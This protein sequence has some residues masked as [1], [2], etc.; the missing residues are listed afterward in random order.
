MN[1]WR[2]NELAGRWKL[3]VAATLPKSNSVPVRLFYSQAVIREHVPGQ[4]C[5]PA[6][7]GVVVCHRA[8]GI[9]G[10]YGADRRICFESDAI[11]A[12][13]QVDRLTRAI[14]HKHVSEVW[15][16]EGHHTLRV[17]ALRPV[18]GDSGNGAGRNRER[19]DGDKE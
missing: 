5:V 8:A 7:H 15:T 10:V 2:S 1:L 17:R 9:G 19:R 14:F 3:I 6:L 16:H 13:R 18:D 11:L 12:L 4:Q